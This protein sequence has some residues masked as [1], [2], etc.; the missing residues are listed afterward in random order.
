MVTRKAQIPAIRKAEY[1]SRRFVMALRPSLY[2]KIK[3]IA[4]ENGISVN[5][6]IH[7][8]VEAYLAQYDADGEKT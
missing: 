8:M 7:Q 6:T 5:D 2:D 1:K 3:R 4:V